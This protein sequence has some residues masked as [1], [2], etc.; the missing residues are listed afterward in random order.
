M[1]LFRV[2]VKSSSTCISEVCACD[3]DTARCMR[4]ALRQ[5]ESGPLDGEEEG[6]FQEDRGELEEL[7]SGEL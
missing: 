3:L 4:D 1:L 5:D 7:E 2:S 6:G